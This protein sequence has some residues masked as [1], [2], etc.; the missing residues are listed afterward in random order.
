MSPEPAVTLL[1]EDCGCDFEVSARY[2]RRIRRGEYELKCR[3]CVRRGKAA[4]I[5]DTDRRFW[6]KRFDDIQLASF[7]S[8]LFD[9]PFRPQCFAERRAEIMGAP[10]VMVASAV[11]DELDTP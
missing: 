7:A 4:P 1:C 5:S 10:Q 8:A 2:A 11:G 3:R 9:A 6:L